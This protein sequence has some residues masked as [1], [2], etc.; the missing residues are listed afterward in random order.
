MFVERAT[1]GQTPAQNL[2]LLLLPAGFSAGPD[3]FSPRGSSDPGPAWE[4]SEGR[5]QSGTTTTAVGP[6]LAIPPEKAWTTSGLA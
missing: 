2:A 5:E 3:R 4:T 1:Q 6:L